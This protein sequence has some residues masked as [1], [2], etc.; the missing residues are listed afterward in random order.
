MTITQKKGKKKKRKKK[1]REKEEEKEEKKEEEEKKKRKKKKKK[2]DDHDDEEEGKGK[3]KKLN[4]CMY[5]YYLPVLPN[6]CS[7]GNNK[8]SVNKNT[9]K[10]CQKQQQKAS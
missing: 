6:S 1:K 4:N 5:S 2:D 7:F 9:F 10:T 8:N 3:G